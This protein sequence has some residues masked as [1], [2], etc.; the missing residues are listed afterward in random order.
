MLF[1]ADEHRSR[2]IGSALLGYGIEQYGVNDLAVNEQN[3]LAKGFYEHLGFIV[4]SGRNSTNREM[5]TSALHEAVVKTVNT[6]H[7]RD[8]LRFTVKANLRR[9]FF[10][11][12]HRRFAGVP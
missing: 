11:E 6:K 5:P 10:M 4:Y 12:T 3:P 8:L 1:V 9:S 7:R 2:G